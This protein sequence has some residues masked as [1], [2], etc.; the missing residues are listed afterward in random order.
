[1]HYY[2]P[3]EEYMSVIDTNV[4]G[5]SD[6]T[7]AFLPLLRKRG[8]DK[9]KRIVNISSIL[10]S[11]GESINFDKTGINSAYKVSKTAVNMLT[12]LFATALEPESF[13][14]I[15][16]HPGWVR[17]DMGGEDAHLEVPDSVRHLINSISGLTT[18][19]N[20]RFLNYDGQAIG[21]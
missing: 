9:V 3:R 15:A 17:T 18:A 8:N 5:V 16:I 7:Q 2:S 6:T 12:A 11:V 4:G 14:V 21:W 20:G 10:G 13:A 1:M 19:D